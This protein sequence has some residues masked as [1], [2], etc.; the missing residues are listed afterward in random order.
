[1]IEN[2]TIFMDKLLQGKVG[3]WGGGPGLGEIVRARG[4]RGPPG[5]SRKGGVKGEAL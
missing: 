4:G 2:C 5:K 1:M 3:K